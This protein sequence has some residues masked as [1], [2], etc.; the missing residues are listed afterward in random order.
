MISSSWV[1]LALPALAQEAAAKPLPPLSPAQKLVAMTPMFL[2]LFGIFYFLVLRPQK[3]EMLNHQNL[4]A[5]LKRG[6]SVVTSSGIVGKVS[7]VEKEFV[8]LEVANNVKIKVLVDHVKNQV[9]S[10]K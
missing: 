5:G 6:D 1:F 7:K 3:K 4:I 8:L 2:M 9:E 10:K